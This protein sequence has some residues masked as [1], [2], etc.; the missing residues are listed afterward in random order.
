MFAHPREHNGVD[1]PEVFAMMK[2][3][4]ANSMLALGL[5]LGVL[6]SAF[7]Q[8]T[9]QPAVRSTVGSLD[10]F[11]TFGY[12]DGQLQYR[13]WTRPNK[14]V[15]MT[16]HAV[17]LGYRCTGLIPG[18]QHTAVVEVVAAVNPSLLWETEYHRLVA[19]YGAIGTKGGNKNIV[20]KDDVATG[21][22]SY[23]GQ[24]HEA[25]C[26]Q[27]AKKSLKDLL[28][29]PSIGYAATLN[30]SVKRDARSPFDIKVQTVRVIL[31][32]ELLRSLALKGLPADPAPVAKPKKAAP[33]TPAA[34]ATTCCVL[35]SA[36]AVCLPPK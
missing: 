26:A 17:Q 23:I 19:I 11:D 33:Q 28:T 15:D 9:P 25:M 21:V 7:A 12:R 13:P 20:N 35:C 14:S 30:E 10:A 27:A 8:T 22:V 29:D 34:P 18:T 32:E 3:G 4:F 31:P 16:E 6:F 24:Q 1:S 5:A 36:A 2:N